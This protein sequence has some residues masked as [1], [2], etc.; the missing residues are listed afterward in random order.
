M[1]GTVVCLAA[2]F[3][4]VEAEAQPLPDGGYVSIFWIEPR[5]LDEFRAGRRQPQC[6][7]PP[8][9]RGEIRRI[10]VRLGTAKPPY[11]DPNRPPVRS[12]EPAPPKE[13]SPWESELQP[14]EP[15]TPTKL[16]PSKDRSQS[17][18]RRPNLDKPPV[19]AE[20]P[21]GALPFNHDT[22]PVPKADDVARATFHQ[23]QPSEQ[24]VPTVSADPTNLKN[25]EPGGR[26]AETPKPWLP[27]TLAIAGLC[28]SVGGNVY[29]GWL[30]VETRRR[31]RALLRRRYATGKPQAGERG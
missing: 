7:I 21:P 26:Q 30:Y 5:E 14:D 31:Y 29:F 12:G 25:V 1:I 6:E 8:K 13:R 15:Q 24:G 2:G 20:M 27:L 17:P 23:P 28:A 11:G 3:L 9:H 19:S 16:V 22:R 10:Q 4:G 18:P